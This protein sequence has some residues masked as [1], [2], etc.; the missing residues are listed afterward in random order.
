MKW[1]RIPK[2]SASQPEQGNYSDWKEIIAEEAERRCV[3]CGIFDSSLGGLRCFH[4]E[5]YKPKSKYGE[6]K[7]TFS[8]LF[9]ACPVC[10]TF[11]NN[12]WPNDPIN[13]HSIISYPN[14]CHVDYT[15]LFE[16]DER[17]VIK[18]HFIASKYMVEKL[19]LNRNQLIMTR[20]ENYLRLKLDKLMIEIKN[21][22]EQIILLD[23]S[24]EIKDI[25]LRYIYIS[26]R[27]IRFQNKTTVE[28]Y[29]NKD[30][31]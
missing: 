18:G 17:G 29:A 15:I 25:F 6:L 27:F 9:Y 21:L 10:N 2:E 11:K 22:F 16:I 30:L 8:N 14:P 23:Y 7:N 1:K 12:D 5:H 20:R 26:E 19:H 13:D 28:L 4:I 3:Y 24:Q 31:Q